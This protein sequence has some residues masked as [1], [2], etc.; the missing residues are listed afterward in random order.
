M[1]AYSGVVLI[2]WEHRRL[3]SLASSLPTIPGTVIPQRWPG[4]RFDV[5]WAFTL[6][7]R[8]APPQYIFGQI[9]QHLLSGDADTGISPSP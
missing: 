3:P 5:I 8:S 7:P 9:P 1:R 4:E 2:C 6:V